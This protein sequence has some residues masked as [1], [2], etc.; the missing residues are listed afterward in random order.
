MQRGEVLGVLD[1]P[2]RTAQDTFDVDARQCF[3][4]EL[5]RLVQLR[6][7]L[8]GLVILVV[9]VQAEQREDQVDRVDPG[10]LGFSRPSCGLCGL[11]RGCERACCP[12]R[13][14]LAGVHVLTPLAAVRS[15]GAPT[16]T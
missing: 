15:H 8:E 14:I 12:F 9:V 7:I 4:P 10:V 6:C 13:Q 3:Q 1:A 11:R 16:G 2:A 5:L